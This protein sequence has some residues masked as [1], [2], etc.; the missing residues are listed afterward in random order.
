MYYLFILQHCKLFLRQHLLFG[1]NIDYIPPCQL[2][3][4]YPVVK[5]DK[6]HQPW[7]LNSYSKK[8]GKARKSIKI[9]PKLQVQ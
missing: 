4:V 3:L 2:L 7:G 5:F 8:I 1:L 9:V 6:T